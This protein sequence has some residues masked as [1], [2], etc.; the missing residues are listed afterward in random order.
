VTAHF[1]A[2]PEGIRAVPLFHQLADMEAAALDA[3][4]IHFESDL[5]SI[6]PA[7]IA[8][9]VSMP[10]PPWGGGAAAVARF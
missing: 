1:T 5:P 4:L 8:R 7:Y 10:T 2:G 6:P 3:R 9:P